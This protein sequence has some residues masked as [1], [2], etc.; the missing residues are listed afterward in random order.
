MKKT[1]SLILIL[2]VVFIAGCGTDNTQPPAQTPISEQLKTTEQAFIPEQT[3][4]PE[5]TQPLDKTPDA[6]TFIGEEKAKEIALSRAGL[7]VADVRFDRVEFDRDGGV[8]HYE[9]EFRQG[10]TEYDA[11]IKADDGTVLKWEVDWDD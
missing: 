1:L 7:S 11:E 4:T 8:W 6:S 9:V 10:R 3:Q 2:L 5:Q